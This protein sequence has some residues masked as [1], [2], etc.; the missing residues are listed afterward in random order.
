MVI[1]PHG[2]TG[3]AGEIHWSAHD[4]NVITGEAE[5]NVV[6]ISNTNVNW[7]T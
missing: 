1:Q 6:V 7:K 4:Q 3:F 2:S 5:P